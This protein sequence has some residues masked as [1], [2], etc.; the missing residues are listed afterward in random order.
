VRLETLE[1]AVDTWRLL[2]N[3]N[4]TI[5][6]KLSIVSGLLKYAKDREW[7]ESVPKIPWQK[8]NTGGRIR[9]Q[10]DAE[11]ATMITRLK[12][13]K[14]PGYA[15]LVAVLADTGFR[16]GEALGIQWIDLNYKVGPRGV[17]SVYETKN[18]AARTLPLTE[19]TLGIFRTLQDVEDPGTGPFWKLRSRQF[20]YW[21]NIEKAAMGLEHDSEF[22]PHCLRHG[23]ATRLCQAGVDIVRLKKWMGHKQISTTM[24]YSHLITSDLEAAAEVLSTRFDE[25]LSTRFDD[26]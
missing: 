13:G 11:E 26:V 2:G 19:R 21:W 3:A 5:N 15:D 1:K 9:C 23:C 16:V 10:S 12:A 14:A 17:V 18:G 22:V 25:A 24:I 20:N 7:L 8:E 6:R 4:S